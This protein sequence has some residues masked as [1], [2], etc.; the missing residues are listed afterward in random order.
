MIFIHNFTA[1][2]HKDLYST[3]SSTH[4]IKNPTLLAKLAKRVGFLKCMQ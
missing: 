3:Y 4:H 1:A 2:H